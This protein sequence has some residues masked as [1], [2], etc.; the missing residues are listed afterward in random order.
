MTGISSKALAFGEPNNK[1][2]YNGK[3]EQRK[4]FSDGSGLEWLDYGARMYDNQIGRW[5]NVDP[6]SE[7][8]FP[9]SPYVYVA[10]NPIKFIDPEGNDFIISFTKG[11][12]G[13]ING[14]I[15]EATVYITGDGASEKR[16]KE[17]NVFSSKNMITQ[18]AKYINVGFKVNY[19]YNNS[20][21]EENLKEGEN[22]LIFTDET[23][24]SYINSKT[25]ETSDGKVVTYTGKT[26][27]ITNRG[28]SN[29]TVL[30]ETYHLLGLSDRYD[31]INNN[32]TFRGTVFPAHKG[33]EKDVMNDSR[34]FTTLDNAHYRYYEIFAATILSSKVVNA[35]FSSDKRVDVNENGVLRTP[36]ESTGYHHS[37]Y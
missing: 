19:V 21:K 26:G 25:E 35:K 17:L 8:Y 2:K 6:L 1:F 15:I 23:G 12:D 13:K 27:T 3:E 33:F 16:A 10:N 37:D 34:N 7:K 14:I 32:L 4:E 5:H 9:L 31:E 28:T 20:I 36:Y 30:H 24:R 22:I 18:K 29:N 11:K